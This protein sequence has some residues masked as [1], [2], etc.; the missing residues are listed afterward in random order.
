M[1]AELRAKC[2]QLERRALIVGVVLLV[3]AA[4]DGLRAPDQ[5]F[6]SYLLAYVFW[7]GLPL[8]CAAF[9]MVH[10]LT[11]GDW[12]LPIKQPLEAGVRTMPLI[13]ALVIPLL[14]GVGRLF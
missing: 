4:L 8:G 2:D 5:F 13:A 7:L 11:G 3:A 12:G 1:I 6:R 9:L 10:Y 14:F